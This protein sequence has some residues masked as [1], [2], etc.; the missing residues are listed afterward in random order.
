MPIEKGIAE[1]VAWFREHK[2]FLSTLSAPKQ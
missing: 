1:F 2:P